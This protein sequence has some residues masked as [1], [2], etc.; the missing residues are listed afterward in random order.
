MRLGKLEWTEWR[1]ALSRD[2]CLGPLCL[3]HQ[4]PE[5]VSPAME[6]TLREALPDHEIRPFHFISERS[7][8]CFRRVAALSGVPDEM[9]KRFHHQCSLGRTLRGALKVRK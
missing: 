5:A 8:A 9:R 2:L 4:L 3:I 6:T 1:K 7:V